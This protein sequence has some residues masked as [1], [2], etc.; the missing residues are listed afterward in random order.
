M[1][2]GKTSEVY[3]FVPPQNVINSTTLAFRAK[4]AA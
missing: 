4:Y 2:W 3:R 1:R